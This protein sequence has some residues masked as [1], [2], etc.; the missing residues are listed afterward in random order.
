MK[1]SLPLTLLQFQNCI[2][3]LALLSRVSLHPN[4]LLAWLFP[5]SFHLQLHPSL[6][7]LLP[8]LSSATLHHPSAPTASS[9]PAYKGVCSWP[10]EWA[11]STLYRRS[12]RSHSRKAFSIAGFSCVPGEFF[13]SSSS[14]L[15]KQEAAEFCASAR[16]QN[17][18]PFSCWFSCPI[19]HAIKLQDLKDSKFKAR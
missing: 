16:A 5:S 4:R 14:F 12:S 9:H 2:Q 17:T 7:R 10:V 6:C 15:K 19:R 18:S 3:P 11:E 1:T 13:P 8:S